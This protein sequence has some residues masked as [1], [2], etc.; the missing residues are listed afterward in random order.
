[1]KS[2]LSFIPKS[3][4]QIILVIWL[5]VQVFPILWMFYSSF[6]PDTDI[7]QNVWSL[8]KSFYLD[9]YIGI[10]KTGEYGITIGRFF[11]NSLIVTGG[12]LILLAIIPALAAYSISKIR[13]PGRSFVI[14][15]MIALISIPTHTVIIPL[16][17]FLNSVHLINNYL[18]LIFVNVAFNIP[19]SILL[20]Q[21]FFR[22]FPDEIIEAA[23]VDGCNELKTFF[24]VVY[25][26]AK[27]AVATVL[28][29][30]FISIWN[31]FLFALII[32]KQNSMKTLPVGLSLFKGTY[33]VDLGML[34]AALASASIVSIIF[35]FIFHR[36]IVSGMTLGAVKE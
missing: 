25:P 17:Y 22:E 6:K 31:E 33:S 35:Y 4:L 1:M 34:I 3:F 30:S 36:S 29:V 26:V 7:I 19:F 5:I 11:F 14:F 18:G 32:M 21:S 20:L 2:R 27:G 24:Y 9:N 8:P 10:W 13:F 16:Y 15:F 28:I 23:K 12:A